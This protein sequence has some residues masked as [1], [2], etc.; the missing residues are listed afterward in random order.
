M[1]LGY[2]EGTVIRLEEHLNTCSPKP[3]VLCTSFSFCNL[4][5]AHVSQRVSDRGILYLHREGNPQSVLVER[6]RILKF[7]DAY[8]Y[9]PTAKDKYVVAVLHPKNIITVR[10]Y[11]SNTSAKKSRKATER[12]LRHKSANVYMYIARAFTKRFNV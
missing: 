4:F 7:N 10:S 6:D 12:A 5:K 2:T 8:L 1:K 3:Y 11:T 9:C